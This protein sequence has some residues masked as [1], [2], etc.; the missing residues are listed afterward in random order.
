MA[1]LGN[2]GVAREPLD[3]DFQWFGA[4]IRVNPD[5]SDLDFMEFMHSAE[6]VELPDDI[7]DLTPAQQMAILNTMNSVTTAMN[8]FVRDQIHPDDWPE[9]WRLA[10]ANRQRNS[11]LMQL[12]RDI[13]A[14]VSRFPTGQQSAS[15]TTPSSTRPRSGAGSSSVGRQ[16]EVMRL[17][18]EHL[19]QRPDLR[20][21]LKRQQAAEVG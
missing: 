3:L 16:Q 8:N 21:A 6:N 7:Q 5:A 1:S 17:A 4:T 18:L 9:F 14:A 12:S 15:T 13:T 2:F 11:D 19:P 20:S 10:K